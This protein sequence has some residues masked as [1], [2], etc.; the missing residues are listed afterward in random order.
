[1]NVAMSTEPL[2]L[3]DR[4][5]TVDDFDELPHD[6]G[7]RYEIIDG[8]LVVSGAP[9]MRH[10]RA[11]FRLARLLD[12]SCPPGLEVFLAPFAVV[13]AHDTVMQPDVI[14]ARVSDLTE[15]ELPAP[16]VLA[17]EVL[18][19]RGHM[20]DLNMKYGRHE[21]AGTPSYWVVEPDEDPAK[22]RLSAWDLDA[23]GHYRLAGEATGE[24]VFRA[25]RPFDVAVSP[26]A[27]VR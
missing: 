27:L 8:V 14:V 6:D 13:L 25:T 19:P 20:I 18:S 1:M 2:V 17:I 24:Q 9:R 5:W 4:H 15:S 22:A 7:N 3:R 26:A 10:Q 16:P 21:R 12:D 11:A 23:A